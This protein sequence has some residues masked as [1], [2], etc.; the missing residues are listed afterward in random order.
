MRVA[1]NRK[2]FTDDERKLYD[3]LFSLSYDDNLKWRQEQLCFYKVG[4]PV[5]ATLTGPK[6]MYAYGIVADVTD[7]DVGFTSVSNGCYISVAPGPFS[8]LEHISQEE[9]EAAK[10]V[11]K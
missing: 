8:G 10:N 6:S 11:T 5:R 3:Y 9:Y 2:S 4:Q 1:L 7:Y